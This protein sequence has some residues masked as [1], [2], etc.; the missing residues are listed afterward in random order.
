MTTYM[1]S[2][3]ILSFDLKVSPQPMFGL[4]ARFFFF[5]GLHS[6]SSTSSPMGP[7]RGG[8]SSPRH[9]FGHA[10]TVHR[11]TDNAPR[12]ARPLATGVQAMERGLTALIP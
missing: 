2:K 9:R 12:I 11:R 3:N 4:G 1:C 6:L 8:G 10:N 7:R 5:F